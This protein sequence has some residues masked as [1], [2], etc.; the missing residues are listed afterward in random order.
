MRAKE[1]FACCMLVFFSA[2]HL[3]PLDIHHRLV[4]EK[5]PPAVAGSLDGG[6]KCLGLSPKLSHKCKCL[7]RQAVQHIHHSGGLPLQAE[8]LDEQGPVL[9]IS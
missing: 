7:S 9:R 8:L 6:W 2:L 5:Q 1:P 4:C 3:F